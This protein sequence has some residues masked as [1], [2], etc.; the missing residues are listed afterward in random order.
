[1][2][3]FTTHRERTIENFMMR[4]CFVS[5]FVFSLALLIDANR[6]TTI[7]EILIEQKKW[8]WNEKKNYVC[9]T[10][11]LKM[12]WNAKNENVIYIISTQI[13]VFANWQTENISQ[14][15]LYIKSNKSIKERVSQ[16]VRETSISSRISFF[17]RWQRLKKI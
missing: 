14:E 9:N 6:K 10:R 8:W 13:H 15:K 5:M 12:L 11:N 17:E 1:M 4:N 16:W 3:N 2:K 7:R